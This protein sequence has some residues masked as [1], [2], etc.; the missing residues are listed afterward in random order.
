MQ[1]LDPLG[2]PGYDIDGFKK[3]AVGKIRLFGGGGK[4]APQVAAPPPPV[5]APPPKK[6]FTPVKPEDTSMTNTAKTGPKSLRI[7][8]GGASADTTGGTGLNIAK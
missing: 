3:N 6:E 5:V 8:L 2:N 7:D 4:G 1:H